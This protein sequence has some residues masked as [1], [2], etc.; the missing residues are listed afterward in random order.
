MQLGVDG[1]DIVV[2]P[3]VFLVSLLAIIFL[4]NKL[5]LLGGKVARKPPHEGRVLESS[6]DGKGCAILED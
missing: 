5:P 3:I 2:F 6:D 1:S 4:G